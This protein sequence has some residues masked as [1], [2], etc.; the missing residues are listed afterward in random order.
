M[1]NIRQFFQISSLLPSLYFTGGITTLKWIA[2]DEKRTRNS[3]Q[4]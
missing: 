1:L 4:S 3:K 2:Q